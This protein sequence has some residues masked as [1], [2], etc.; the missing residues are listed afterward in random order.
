MNGYGCGSED[1]NKGGNGHF[2]WKIVMSVVVLCGTSER[3]DPEKSHTF[4]QNIHTCI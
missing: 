2:V 4:R 3:Y 1:P